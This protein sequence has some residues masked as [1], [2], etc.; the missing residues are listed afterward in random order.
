MDYPDKQMQRFAATGPK[1]AGSAP[2]AGGDS[3]AQPVAGPDGA[4][5]PMKPPKARLTWID[6]AK[7][8]SMV[9]VV[10][11]HS[12]GWYVGGQG[13][14][15]SIWLDFTGAVEPLRIPLFFVVSGTLIA[16]RIDGDPPK[17]LRRAASLLSVYVL[18]TVIHAS[19]LALFPGLA[20]Q[21]PLS[22]ELILWTILTPG[23]Y[24]YIWA[25]PL[26][27]SVTVIVFSQRIHG[28]RSAY[29]PYVAIVMAAL[30][31]FFWAELSD[32]W[33]NALALEARVEYDFTGSVV[34]N[35]FWFLLGVLFSKKIIAQSK[36]IP[37]SGI[38]P[39]AIGTGLILAGIL[40]AQIGVHAKFSV[41]PFF[42]VPGAIILL[43]RLGESFMAR[44]LVK[45]GTQT[46]S[47]YIFHFFILNALSFS[48]AVF[49]APGPLPVWLSVAVPPLMTAMIVPLT[50]A[51]ENVLRR[52]R[53]GVVLDGIPDGL[54]KYRRSASVS[55][56]A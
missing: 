42:M 16:S 20:P 4:A 28:K 19:R 41:A 44:L 9:L 12:A 11:G 17:V 43:R 22:P 26:Y 54:A 2:A 53:L 31:S 35:Y 21:T 13:F 38:R 56:A 24:W 47:V 49:V 23:I 50:M 34:R 18:W 39:L 36:A 32:L 1:H 15:P 45:V 29:G 51:A 37:C 7:G 30:C 33:S 14:G 52:L 48:A 5:W 6:A 46:L 10:L 27:Y 40:V 25:L 3:A 8:L 55:Q